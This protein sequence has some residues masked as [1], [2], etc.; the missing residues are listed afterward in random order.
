MICPLCTSKQI[1]DYYKDKR[2]NY[3]TCKICSLVFVEPS[4]RLSKIEEKAEYDKHE[5]SP[6]DAGYRTFLT[7]ML[8]PIT[9]MIKQ[10]SNG[11]DFGCGPGPTLSI[12]FRE[13]GYSVDDYDLF[14]QND[15]SVFCKKYDFITSTEVFEHL[16]EPGK[17]IS[18]LLDMIETH[19]VLGIMTKRVTTIEAFSN[20]HY[21]NDM[22]HVCFF[23]EKT[24]L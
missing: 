20:W 2:R 16:F 18:Q 13:L 21:K 5:N 1:S 8:T 22:T 14:Y 6:N 3:H 7:R 10:N 23:S 19:G 4:Q 24:F 17:I 9:S 11:L 12:M 15:K